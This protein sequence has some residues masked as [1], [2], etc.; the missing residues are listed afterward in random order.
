MPTHGNSSGNSQ[1][2]LSLYRLRRVN[3]PRNGEASP[4]ASGRPASSAFAHVFEHAV[5]PPGRQ[6]PKPTPLLHKNATQWQ[7]FGEARPDPSGYMS[8]TF[9]QT[10]ELAAATAPGRCRERPHTRRAVVRA[11]P[12]ASW[13]CPRRSTRPS[14]QSTATPHGAETAHRSTGPTCLPPVLA[15]WQLPGNVRRAKQALDHVSPS[16][17]ACSP[18]RIF[19]KRV[20]GSVMRHVRSKPALSQDQ[21]CPDPRDRLG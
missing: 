12:T 16:L 7:G 18:G 5:G 10:R 6:L 21:A 11:D 19:S 20:S 8:D 3:G 13:Q 2:L 4:T 1:A 9:P 17:E 14:T 15:E